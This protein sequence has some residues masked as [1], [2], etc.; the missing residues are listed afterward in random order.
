[1]TE[2]AADDHHPSIA[3]YVKVAV[4]LAIITAVEIVIIL[5]DVKEWYRAALPWF[6]PLVLPILFLLS[7]VKFAA[8]VGYFMHLAQDKGAPR[9]VFLAPLGL[10]LAMILVLMLLYGTLI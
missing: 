9:R 3:F 1:M 7:I 2:R 8:V 10:A 5:P 6:V 4:I